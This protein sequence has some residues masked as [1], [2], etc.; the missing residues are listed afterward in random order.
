MCSNFE[1]VGQRG[2]R[3]RLP[4]GILTALLKKYWPGLYDLSSG[5]KQL[6]RRWEDYEVAKAGGFMTD[7]TGES[8]VPT[9]AQVVHNQFWV[10]L[11]LSSFVHGSSPHRANL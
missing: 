10:R 11:L 3:P 7:E 2:S 6:A 9:Y 4:G 1:I 8:F 5:G